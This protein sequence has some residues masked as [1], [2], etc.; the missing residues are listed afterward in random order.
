M[1][2]FIYNLG[3]VFVCLCNQLLIVVYFF[4]ASLICGLLWRAGT[5]FLYMYLH[6]DI[7]SPTYG[8]EGLV[9]RQGAGGS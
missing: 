3:E 2:V 6:V 8:R 5:L 1:P 7:L 9:R 4:G